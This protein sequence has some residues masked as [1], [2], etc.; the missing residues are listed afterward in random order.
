MYLFSN[1]F[2]QEMHE[3]SIYNG[4]MSLAFFFSET[5]P[6]NYNKDFYVSAYT[7]NVGGI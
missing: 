6:R 5:T 1:F 4:V 7:T 2:L 3:M